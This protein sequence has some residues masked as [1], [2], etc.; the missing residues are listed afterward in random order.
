MRSPTKLNHRLVIPVH[1]DDSGAADQLVAS[2]P[3][4]YWVQTLQT[5]TYVDLSYMET[6]Y[7]LLEKQLS[8]CC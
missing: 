8:T 3:D 7:Y 1:N 4:T 2:E 6:A 5:L